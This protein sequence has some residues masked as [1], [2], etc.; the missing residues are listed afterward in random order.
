MPLTNGRRH[1]PR[2]VAMSP[3]TLDH[4]S[5][6]TRDPQG[7]L[8]SVLDLDEVA[9]MG[10]AVRQPYKLAIIYKGNSTQQ[11]IT[12]GDAKA[13]Q[14]AIALFAAYTRTKVP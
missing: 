4:R 3:H 11:V 8:V 5:M 10:V 13:V 7:A 6:V 2:N 9:W 12:Y 1:V 14:E